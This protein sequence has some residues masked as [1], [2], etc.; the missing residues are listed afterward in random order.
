MNYSKESLPSDSL[1]RIGTFQN[2]DVLIFESSQSVTLIR[3]VMV[4]ICILLGLV[5]LINLIL[6]YVKNRAILKQDQFYRLIVPVILLL[7]IIFHVAHYAHNI[8]D[9]AGYF[10]PKHLYEK[11]IFSEMEQTFLFNFP[12]SILFII[13]T[14]K[15]LSC[16]T[17]QQTNLQ[18][19]LFLTV[20]YS[21]L[22]M[23]SGGH[24]AYEPPW[25]FS[26][27]FNITI[28]GETTV[29]FILLLT[30]VYVY[31]SNLKQTF[32]HRYTRLVMDENSDVGVSLAQQRQMKSKLSDDE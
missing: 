23:I 17:K 30:A 2:K 19:M 18:Q 28:A 11:L 26:L 1:F 31:R 8:Y 16:C 22:S 21:L 7:N 24:Y 13:V 14:R 5:T 3:I 10:E 20:L 9:P 32:N 6:V 25:N 12:L 29:A 15:V 27:I 4:I